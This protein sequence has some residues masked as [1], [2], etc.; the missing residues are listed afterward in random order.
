MTRRVH[1]PVILYTYRG[2]YYI[3]PAIMTRATQQAFPWPPFPRL[4]RR[5]C[6]AAWI[7]V[8]LT[9]MA[10]LTAAAEDE[11]F[12][13]HGQ[14][15]YVEQ[16]TSDFNA[17]YRGTNSL[18]PDKGA[19][20]TDATLYL[21]A[22]LWSGAEGWINGE[23]DQGFGLD[24][25]LGVAGFPSGEAYKVGKNQPYLRLARMFVRQTVDLGGAEQAVEP[26]ANW[27]GGSHS[28]DRVVLWL[29]K[30]SVVDVFDTNQ[31]A[32][33]PRADFL[34]WTAIDA[35]TFDYAADAWGYTVGAAV[36][37]YQGPWTVRAGLFD[38]SDVPNSV[39]LEP[40]F[41]EFQSALELE[42]RHEFGGSSG[43]LMLTVYD[44]RGRMGLLEQAIQQSQSSGSPVDI[45]AVRAYRSRTGASLNLEQQL[46][47]DLGAFI[48][49][50]KASGN[51]EAYE[52][53][54][55]DRT[56]S[57]GLA[58]QGSRWHRSEDTVGVAAVKSGISGAREA[59]LNAGGLGILVGDGQL[60]HPGPEQIIETYYSAAVLKFAHLSLD[61]QW[62]DHPAYNRD[63]GPVSV[64]AVR[65]HAQF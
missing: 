63:R 46:A 55:M 6:R 47:P 28:A 15:T 42:H 19:E 38:L 31:Y 52:F 26:Q 60:P 10:T 29:G 7:G 13:V 24:D 44:S 59:Y 2:V 20:T 9:M 17:P 41:H 22:R 36:E 27:L 16:S 33:D 51:V 30:F 25:T 12:A 45:A 11:A 8:A 35:G 4:I 32:H 49:A 40:A 23:I 61:Y 43:R 37:W 21:G 65:L 56:L 58:L 62:I 53:T 14:F 34:N 50:G 48:R 1:T 57:A 54:D 3:L 5:R 64:I 39:H 18:T